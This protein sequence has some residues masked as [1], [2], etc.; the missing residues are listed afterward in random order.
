MGRFGPYIFAFL[1]F[2]DHGEESRLQRS[3][4]ASV[5]DSAIYLR[6]YHLR[7]SRLAER[8]IPEALR[9]DH[10]IIH[11]WSDVSQHETLF[12]LV[13]TAVGL[14]ICRGIII[15]WITVHH[16]HLAGVSYFAIF[17]AAAGYAAQGSLTDTVC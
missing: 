10:G 16:K 2:A 14:T 1:H 5:D 3:A 6:H 12:N 9:L 4:C 8:P 13:E 15:L 7:D 17:L 11:P